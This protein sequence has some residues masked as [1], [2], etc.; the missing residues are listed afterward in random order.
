MAIKEGIVFLIPIS[1]QN[2]LLKYYIRRE[3]EQRL[4]ADKIMW[5]DIDIDIE[6]MQGTQLS[7]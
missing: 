7:F 2:L 1:S 4:S 6:P 3:N 5:P